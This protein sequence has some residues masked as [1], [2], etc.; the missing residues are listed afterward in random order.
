MRGGPP[1]VELQE[2]WGAEEGVGVGLP[3]VAVG[4]G[5]SDG[6]GE[7]ADVGVGEVRGVDEGP[8]VPVDLDPQPAVM[9]ITATRQTTDL[10]FT[11]KSTP[12][13]DK[14]VQEPTGFAAETGVAQWLLQSGVTRAI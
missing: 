4:L 1:G 3:D 2:N 8:A 14:T 10:P 11:P 13:K 6:D 5:G 12:S 9:T 7:T